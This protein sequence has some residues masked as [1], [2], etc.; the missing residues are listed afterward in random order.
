MA[1]NTVEIRWHARGGQGAKSAA[2]MVAEVALEEDKFGQ[3]C[4][5]YGP[6]RRGAPTRGYTRISDRPITAHCAIATPDV[7]VVLDETLLDSTDVCDGM[8]EGGTVLVNTDKSPAEI[9]ER[10]GVK[11]GKVFTIDAT[12]VSL[13]TIG[14]PFPNTPM[15]GA[16]IK[17]TGILKLDT[18]LHDVEKKFGRK[19]E[20]IVQGNKDA[21]TR[22]HEEVQSE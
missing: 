12:Q 21:I 14:R 4:P 22:A 10:L 9:R 8:K 17:A 19:G 7:V 1:G 16:L 13:D 20:K 3:G 18:I 2:I 5:D 11:G 15:V 6:E